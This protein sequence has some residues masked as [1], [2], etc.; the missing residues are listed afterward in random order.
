MKSECGVHQKRIPRLILDDL[1]LEEK[2]DLEMHLAECSHCRAEKETY[3]QTLNMLKSA[4]EEPV[5]RHFFVYPK[6]SGSNP[7]QLFRRMNLKWQGVSIAAAA[8]FLLISIAAVSRLG[9]HFYSNGWMLSFGG[10]GINVE[11]LREDILAAADAKT[12]E[13]K[14]V[15]MD[16]VKVESARSI[17]DLSQKQQK[18]LT[19]ALNRLDARLSEHILLAE[20]RVRA[21]TQKLAVDL[22]RSISQQRAQDLNLI[23]LRLGRIEAS[24]TIKARQTDAILDTLLQ[25]AELRLR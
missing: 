13:A 24:N 4:E 15:W 22:Y 18:E 10:N 2:Q 21:D 23:D 14:A 25:E 7:W 3:V 20:D 5:P 12:R 1:S 19:I 9:I 16:D 17:S 11:A 8:M 6:E